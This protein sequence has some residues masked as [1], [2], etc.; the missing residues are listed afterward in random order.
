MNKLAILVLLILVNFIISI[1]TYFFPEMNLNSFLIYHLWI[2]FI[3]LVILF[4]PSKNI[5]FLKN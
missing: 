2:N 3:L 4:I 5:I 1:L